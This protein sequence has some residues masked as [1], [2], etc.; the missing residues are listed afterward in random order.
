MRRFYSFLI[1]L[2]SFSLTPYAYAEEWTQTS[3][4]LY[5]RAER[6]RKFTPVTGMTPSVIPMTNG[7]SF[8]LLWKP[9]GQLPQ[10][11]IVS[12]PGSKGFATDE[13]ALWSRTLAG[14]GIGLV[15]VQWWLGT[16]DRT[17][18]YLALREIYREIDILLSRI[19]VV[20][21]SALLHGFSRGSAN[22]YAIAALDRMKGHRYFDVIVA[23]S[24][25][26]SVDYPPT[27]DIT[28]GVYGDAPF[29]GTR[30][31]TVCGYKDPNPDRDGC[32]AME[33]T[34]D[35]LKGYGATIGMVIQDP[36]AGHG[37]LHTNPVNAKHL[38][39]WYTGTSSNSPASGENISH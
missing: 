9:T 38:I 5:E 12:L 32:P 30:W 4:S 2:V 27:H 23:N 35:W 14:M 18:D 31:V 7:K 25:G 24:G 33:R 20:S 8:F 28:T 19:G 15:E 6:E 36:A 21:H 3:K 34:A 10:Q 29:R 17:E 11:W 1:L 37:A 16:G 26:A 22:I 39:D 13:F